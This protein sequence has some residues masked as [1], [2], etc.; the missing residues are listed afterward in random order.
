MTAAEIDGLTADDR[1][2]NDRNLVIS[3]PAVDGLDADRRHRVV[4]GEQVERIAAGTEVDRQSDCVGQQADR[5][6][7]ADG[8]DRLDARERQT[9]AWRTEYAERHGIRATPEVEAGLQR[10]HAEI[11]R[12]RDLVRP[13]VAD[14]VLDVPYRDIARTQDGHGVGGPVRP[15]D[16][17]DILHRHG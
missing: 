13:A 10:G 17:L 7:A 16:R 12:Q 11:G 9:D 4:A 1:I 15:I 5:F 3:G 6:D 8:V 2:R 14:D